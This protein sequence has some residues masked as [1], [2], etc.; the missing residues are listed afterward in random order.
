ML[1]LCIAF[2]GGMLIFL[3][4]IPLYI[5]SKLNSLIKAVSAGIKGISSLIAISF[6]VAGM[7]KMVYYSDGINYTGLINDVWLLAGLILC[8]AGDVALVFSITAGGSLFTLAHIS[9]IIFFLRVGSFTPVSIPIFSLC[10]VA[11]MCSL[12]QYMGSV[13][14]NKFRLIAY[15][16]VILANCSIGIILPFQIGINGFLPAIGCVLLGVSDYTLLRNTF[17]QKT[18]LSDCISLNTYYAGLFLLSLSLYL[19][20]FLVF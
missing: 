12:Y 3:V 15:G 20:A 18:V 8:L 2:S 1:P 19:K 6:G 11:V 14:K 9:Y 7:I 13:G 17:V 16:A 5:G 10:V 4:L